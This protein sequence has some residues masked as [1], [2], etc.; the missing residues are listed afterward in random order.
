MLDKIINTL[1]EGGLV[2]LPSDTVY[3]LAVDATNQKAVNKLLL[4][5]ER[6]PGKAISVFVSDFKMAKDYAIIDK[7]A[8]IV[9]SNL[10]PGPFTLIVKGKHR[11]AKGIEAEDGS[12]GIRI[13]DNKLILELV[14][15]YGKPITATSANLSGRKPH[16]SIESF[17]KTLSKKKKGMIDL[18]VDEGKLPKNKPSTVIDI[19]EPEI[20]VLR[21]GELIAKNSKT[22]ISKS[23]CETQK[24]ADYVFEKSKKPVIFGLSGDLGTG[25]TIFSQEIGKL[26]GIKEKITSPTYVIYN[27]YGKFLHMDL[28]KIENNFELDEIDFWKIIKTK[29]VCIEWIENLGE[30][31]LK[32]LK[33]ENNLVLIN[34][35]YVD[36]KTREIKL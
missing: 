15:K 13:P 8:E 1:R 5:K 16:Y 22:F 17:L 25:K 28:Y 20:K 19:R 4:F 30:K 10:I 7:N 24:I 14:K 23:V 9:Y 26:A 11:L 36:E 35:E 32:K 33:K 2:V 27:D 29:I 21:R 18:I 34:F 12:L 3:G 6:W 31:N